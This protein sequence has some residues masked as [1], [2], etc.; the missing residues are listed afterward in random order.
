MVCRCFASVL[1]ADVQG[2]PLSKAVQVVI[3]ADTIV[4]ACREVWSILEAALRHFRWTDNLSALVHDTRKESR[5]SMVA[6]VGKAQGVIFELLGQKIE[7]LMGSLVFINFEPTVMPTSPH[8]SVEEIIDFLEIT[9][10]SLSNLPAAMKA[11][12]LQLCCAHVATG[13]T[14]YILSP[15]VKR[16]NVFCILALEMDVKRLRQFADNS[17]VPDLRKCFGEFHDIVKAVLHPE[18]PQLA[19]N[20]AKRQQLFPRLPARKLASLLDKITPSSIYASSLNLPRLER[21]VLL[22][23]VKKLNSVNYNR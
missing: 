9:F 17:E 19:D 18:L 20:P 12:C 1:T 23:L 4:A 10:M 22:Q 21:A 13:I 2:I 14:S 16:I 8:E 11:T 7:D 3:D 6:L 5:A 15:Q